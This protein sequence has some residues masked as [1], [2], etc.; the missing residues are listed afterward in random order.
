MDVKPRRYTPTADRLA[1]NELERLKRSHVCPAYCHPCPHFNG[2][3]FPQCYGS[4]VAYGDEF[5]LG[6]CNCD[7]A[8]PIIGRQRL[9]ELALRALEQLRDRRRFRQVQDNL[10]TQLRQI[11]DSM[12]GATI[13]SLAPR[14]AEAWRDVRRIAYALDGALERVEERPTPE[15]LTAR[16]AQVLR[17]MA[18]DYAA[19]TGPA[20]LLPFARPRDER[21]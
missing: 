2:A 19:P 14:E 12:S 15:D 10:V 9:G 11:A 3:I 4:A 5:D 6:A 8:D 13:A 20:P 7:P 17:E 21:I 1:A 16:R 18:T